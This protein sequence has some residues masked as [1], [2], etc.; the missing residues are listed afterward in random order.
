M[1]IYPLRTIDC[2]DEKKKKQ[3]QWSFNSKN[4]EVKYLDS[5]S[6]LLSWLPAE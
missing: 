2:I 5:L 4:Y 1:V 6:K 3:A